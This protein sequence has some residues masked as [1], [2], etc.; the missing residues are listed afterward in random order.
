MKLKNVLTVALAITL[1]SAMANRAQAQNGRGRLVGQ[2]VSP[3]GAP[4]GGARLTLQVAGIG[5]PAQAV[6]APNGRF[7]FVLPAA[8]FG[9]VATLTSTRRMVGNTYVQV[10]RPVVIPAP[11]RG[12]ADVGQMREVAPIVLSQQDASRRSRPPARASVDTG[13]L[14][15]GRIPDAAVGTRSHTA[16]QGPFVGVGADADRREMEYAAEWMKRAARTDVY[17]RSSPR[18]IDLTVDSS[19]AND[20]GATYRAAQLQGRIDLDRYAAQS[21]M[22]S[23]ASWRGA[24]QQMPNGGCVS[25]DARFVY[26]TGEFPISPREK[27]PLGRYILDKRTGR[28]TAS[29]DGRWIPLREKVLQMGI[30]VNLM[31]TQMRQYLLNMQVITNQQMF[32]W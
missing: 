17:N 15:S 16:G 12:V 18:G 14:S 31:N 3:Q 13:A 27:L 11:A 32:N 19:I 22:R 28:W 20:A 23:H 1:G 5:M 29:S 6:T 4:V 10:N 26:Y 8:A 25:A 9:R 30:V 7:Q 2:V 24:C 21:A